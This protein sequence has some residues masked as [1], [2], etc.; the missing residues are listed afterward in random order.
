M[1]SPL[2]QGNTVPLV[3]VPDS[4]GEKWGEKQN[5]PSITSVNIFLKFGSI[6]HPSY[7]QVNQAIIG[8]LNRIGIA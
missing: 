3:A 8:C 2:W 7:R 4:S 1:L 5:L 6:F